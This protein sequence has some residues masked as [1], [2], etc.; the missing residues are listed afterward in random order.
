MFK[1]TFFNSKYGIEVEDN[2]NLV[3]K[4]LSINHSKV[5]RNNMPCNEHFDSSFRVRKLHSLKYEEQ[6][7]QIA[8]MI[9]R[10]RGWKKSITNSSAKWKNLSSDKNFN[11]NLP[12]ISKKRS[13]VSQNNS[14][15]DKISADSLLK[16]SSKINVISDQPYYEK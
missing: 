10:T 3:Q 9:K 7:Y 12:N 4:S 5:M 11:T 16:R 14:S 13:N 6:G 2:E 8:G 15:I 1:K